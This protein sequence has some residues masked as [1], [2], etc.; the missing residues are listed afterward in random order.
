MFRLGCLLLL[1]AFAYPHPAHH[2]AHPALR[3]R[4]STQLDPAAQ[5]EWYKPIPPNA[6]AVDDPSTERPSES[7]PTA[8]LY[9]CY[10]P[11]KEDF[12]ALDMWKS[13]AEMWAIN[14]IEIEK[15]N[16]GTQYNDA[17][18][19]AIIKQSQ[20]SLVDAR[21]ILAMVMQESTGQ[22]Q[23]PCTP[24]DNP[25]DCGILQIRGGT[26]FTDTASIKLMLKEGME[27]LP[28]AKQ[29]GERWPGL[30]AHFN[31]ESKVNAYAGPEVW[32]HN[33]FTAVH[34]Y[35][36]GNLASE[37]L[38]I[39]AHDI[40]ARLVGWNGLS[41]GKDSASGGSTC[42]RSASSA[43]VRIALSFHRSIATSAAAMSPF[44]LPSHRNLFIATP[45]AIHLHSRFEE[46]ILFEC[47]APDGILNAKHSKD[48]SGI[49]AVADSQVV[50]ICDPQKGHN[51]QYKLKNGD[52]EPRM[53]LFSPDSHMLYFT[54]TL[55]HSVQAYSITT[56]EL[57]P[58][59][60]PHP[61]P[62]TVL[63]ICQD[64]DILLSA[65]A[66]P[67]T[68]LIH[69]LRFPE[70][71]PLRLSFR[72]AV[73]CA[74]FPAQVRSPM[75]AVQAVVLGF[76]NGTLAM[77]DLP[78]LP[79]A[80]LSATREDNQES[81]ARPQP[82]Q[83]GLVQRVHRGSLGGVRAAEYIPGY[84][85]RVV[86]MGYDAK[87]RIVDFQEGGDIV[88][89]WK[90]EDIP[91]CLS[92]IPSEDPKSA[93]QMPKDLFEGRNVM[94]TDRT[95]YRTRRQLIAL[96]TRTGDVLIYDMLGLLVHEISAGAPIVALENV[97]NA[98]PLP[99]LLPPPRGSSLR[100]SLDIHR[101]RG[102][103]M[104]RM[105]G[106]DGENSG[107]V[108]MTRSPAMHPT[109]S[110]S[111][112]FRAAASN[113]FAMHSRRAANR[114]SPRPPT[115][116][117]F[118]DSD[119]GSTKSPTKHAREKSY[120][121]PR[122]AT[123]TFRQPSTTSGADASTPTAGSVPSL[124]LYNFHNGSRLHLTSPLSNQLSDDQGNAQIVEKPSEEA[125]DPQNPEPE[126]KPEADE[127]T[128]PNTKT[129]GG[130]LN[131]KRSLPSHSSRPPRRVRF[132]RSS[133]S[134][135]PPVPLH[136]ITVSGEGSHLLAKRTSLTP[137]FNPAEYT[138]T[139][140]R[141]SLIRRMQN[142]LRND[143]NEE[144]GDVGDKEKDKDVGK[145]DEDEDGVAAELRALRKEFALLREALLAQPGK[146]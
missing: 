87:C 127:D 96:S 32:K 91:N 79:S 133:P 35:N 9:K 41:P 59:S 28:A 71:K 42:R 128:A 125:E 116:R 31:G 90:V 40:A 8:I 48:N 136:S 64:A 122:I 2:H 73:T 11:T 5:A 1:S 43:S 56:A 88:R 63:A 33:P 53:L 72:K 37:N 54:T 25:T 93:I 85:F 7:P 121:R 137:I 135:I 21:L 12:P 14:V 81:Q 117:D 110:A 134:V 97:S 126:D 45:N 92:V 141:D 144:D 67:P 78:L 124:P 19:Q 16:G 115:R 38:G 108:R 123:E 55:S 30:L 6:L 57:L 140:K 20:E 132:R 51:R 3:L 112:I 98:K 106:E 13:F 10:G 104:P 101:I 68:V 47:E 89:T 58:A 49:L 22:A 23:A 66:E 145:S 62:P 65:S 27:G 99:P 120:P 39:Y 61:S 129:F 26:S 142:F 95:Q 77:Y 60:F 4:F 146:V 118:A 52:G 84:P 107:T 50:I 70:R 143:K 44:L 74:A 111:N 100:G 29:G 103:Y 139:E 94:D 131:H 46:K 34:L 138:E 109:R 119:D 102:C 86:T 36:V 83:V 80:I 69:F 76:D 17:I 113:L 105:D 15:I 114:S 75:D 82:R 130:I 24:L 18:K